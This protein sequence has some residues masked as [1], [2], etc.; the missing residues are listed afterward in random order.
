[1]EG[2]RRACQGDPQAMIGVTGGRGDG[3]GRSPVASKDVPGMGE[4]DA[5]GL[6]WHQRAPVRNE[7]P[8]VHALLKGV[9]ARAER[10]GRKV[11]DGGGSAEG[12]LLGKHDKFAQTVQ[13]HVVTSK[14]RIKAS[15]FIR[16]VL[17]SEAD[18]KRIILRFP[19][20]GI[21]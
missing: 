7:Q 9:Q 2:Q 18:F 12:A 16:I 21:K 14:I 4:K 13:I 11:K 19:K 5:T 20:N 10:G 15:S 8:G 17:R 6:R 3:V 1:M